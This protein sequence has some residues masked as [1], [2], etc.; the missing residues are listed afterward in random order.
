M[1][2]VPREIEAPKKKPTL[3]AEGAPLKVR[4]P[5]GRVQDKVSTERPGKGKGDLS[6]CGDPVCRGKGD[7]TYNKI[8]DGIPSEAI[9]TRGIKVPPGAWPIFLR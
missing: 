1:S 5:L 9:S 7:N 4:R 6:L 2:E 8:G 3:L